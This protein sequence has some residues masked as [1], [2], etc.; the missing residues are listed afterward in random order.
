[1][2]YA[3]ENIGFL[4]WNNQHLNILLL[5]NSINILAIIFS[6]G[7]THLE[8][9]GGESRIEIPAKIVELPGDIIFL[10]FGSRHESDIAYGIIEHTHQCIHSKK[11]MLVEITEK[12]EPLHFAY[13]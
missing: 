10:L 12:H 3:A 1:M 5:D 6:A 8:R 2:E 9:C 4:I 13:R 11:V 7:D